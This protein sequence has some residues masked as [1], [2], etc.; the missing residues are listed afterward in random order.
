MIGII[1]VVDARMG[2]GK[3]S[4]AMRYM[5]ENKD[6]KR[7][8]YITPFLSEVDR[9]CKTC[10]FDQP[11][12]KLGSKSRTL[13]NHL[14][15]GENVAATHSLFYL[16]DSEAKALLH[17]KHYT[18]IVDESISLIASE[19]I[20]PYDKKLLLG[21]CMEEDSDY[22]L[23]WTMDDYK[24]EFS[25]LRKKVRSGVL[26]N[27]D[28]G[29]MKIASPDILRAC[30]DV[31]MLTYMLEGQYQYAYLRYFNFDYRVIGV[32]EDEQGFFFSDTPDAPP[33]VDYSE[34]IHIVDEPRLNKVGDDRYALS[35]SWFEGHGASSP[36]VIEL[37]NN[38]NTYYK[39]RCRGSRA[40]ER[41]W[42]CFKEHADKLLGDRGRYSDSFVQIGARATNDLSDRTRLAYLGNRFT[43][44]NINKFFETK[45]IKIDLDKFAK[46]EML[47]WIWRSAIRN[48]QEI[49]L[50]IPSSRMR[51]FLK[52]WMAEVSRA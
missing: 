18:L 4:A 12:L 29:L 34:L 24:G 16:M 19:P 50:Y 38:L 9:V 51:W 42:T 28:L 52:E 17:D 11:D 35:L 27:T 8:L 43:D 46:A 25:E 6:T 37:R 22:R 44:P 3:S 32:G 13:K 47:Q 41:M 5:N 7:F 30:D 2:R 20:S 36:E 45:G 26:Y 15:K 10:D 48:N 31:F 33:S 14:T 39:Y 1:T 21:T 49:W 23:I 40:S